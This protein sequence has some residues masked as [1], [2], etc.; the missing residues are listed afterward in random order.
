MAS[1]SGILG[2]KSATKEVEFAEKDPTGRYI[3]YDD[4]LGKGAFKTVYKAFDE[5]DGI[6]VAWNLVSIEDVMQMPG[7]LERLYSEVHLLKA[8]KHENIIKLFNSWVDDKNKTINMITEL[9]TSGSLRAYRKKHRKVD[10]KAI[11]NWA[12]QILRGL[13]YLHTQ[14]PPVI[15]RDLKCD[16]I[17]INGN[18]GG[19]KIGDLG[20]AAVMQQ[21]TARSVIGT[22]E[23]MAPELYE[24]EYNELV[25]IYSFGM[26]MLEM[27]T[28]E[29]PYSECRN[30]AQIYKKVTSG[31]KPQSLSKLD[32][33]QVK[34]LIEKCLLPAPLRPTALELLKDP[35]L[36]TD[37]AKD[38][39]YTASSNG[40]S[41]PVKP[42]Q[43]DH[44]PMDVDHN[45]NKSASVCSSLI[46][47]H[48]YPWLQTLELQRVAEN[49]EFRLRG[50]RT[51]D[52]TASMTLR[53]A[54][55]SGQARI[56]HFAFYLNSDTATAI[57]EE[58]VE[59]LDLSGQEVIVIAEMIDD[60]IMKLISNRNPSL[61]CTTST[62]LNSLYAS[63]QNSPYLSA[64]DHMN[65]QSAHSKNREAGGSVNSDISAEYYFAV[66]SNGSYGREL[67]NGSHARDSYEGKDKTREAEAEAKAVGDSVDMRSDM[68]SICSLSISE[69]E[70]MEDLK[71]ELKTIESQFQQSL[72]ELLR[73]R[74]E[75][76]E[77]AK[78]KWTVKRQA[79]PNC[80]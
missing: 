69:N 72:Q 49:K 1:G 74:E 27:V 18:T 23:F 59:Q 51:D 76:I 22:P 38:S 28:C 5:V 19:V 26:C 25:D 80:T 17:F 33:C 64:G 15:H 31:I 44:L 2:G 48:E 56:V 16:N 73:L 63:V 78:R 75:A 77:N 43:P 67:D 9:F 40:M 57:A 45:D 32:D 46:S 58:M 62:H 55:L 65:L 14:S 20:L 13:H 79:S 4:I 71:A 3:R 8:L 52:V 24:E 66:A 61:S 47:N 68:A 60:L 36:A 11:K 70:Q 29:Y 34:Q 53:I 39:A 35:F 30:Q 10:P 12:R 54:D 6:E 21:P 42:P 41:K 37:G 7:Q 50:E